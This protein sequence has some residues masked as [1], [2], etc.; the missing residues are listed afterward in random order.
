MLMENSDFLA[1]KG[2]FMWDRQEFTLLEPIEPAAAGAD[3]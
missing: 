1:V 2:L 3:P